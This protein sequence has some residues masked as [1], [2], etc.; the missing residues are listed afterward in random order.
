[1]SMSMHVKV[2]RPGDAK[3]HRMKGAYDSCI[4]AGVPVPAEVNEFFNFETPDEKG[5]EIELG[6]PYGKNHECC[7]PYNGNG[8]SGF[9]IDIDKV[10]EGVKTIRFYCSW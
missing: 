8:E 4:A 1:M 3:W 6:A 2:F 5:V 10:P 9:E 7:T